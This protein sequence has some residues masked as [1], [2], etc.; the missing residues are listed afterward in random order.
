MIPRF[1]DYGPLRFKQ[2]DINS[3][4]AA[5]DKLFAGMAKKGNGR[6]FP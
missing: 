2:V 6:P 5:K 4:Y 3:T 1:D